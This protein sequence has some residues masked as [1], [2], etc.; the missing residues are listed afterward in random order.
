MKYFLELTSFEEAKFA[1]IAHIIELDINLFD[2][3]VLF[4]GEYGTGSADAAGAG[5]GI[6]A[7]DGGAALCRGEGAYRAREGRAI[8]RRCGR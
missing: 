7:V 6:A 8:D 2:R 3:F 1:A 4:V 5:R